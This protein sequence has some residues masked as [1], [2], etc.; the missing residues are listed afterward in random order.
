MKYTIQQFRKD[1]PGDDACPDEPLSPLPTGGRELLTCIS[2][3]TSSQSR[4]PTFTDFAF[5][6]ELESFAYDLFLLDG[7]K[8]V[9]ARDGCYVYRAS[10]PS[11]SCRPTLKRGGRFYQEY[12]E[13]DAILQGQGLLRDRHREAVEH[14]LAEVRR[15]RGG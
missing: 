13:V 10:Y 5:S 2:L 9:R 6:S 14:L 3:L 1:Y 11:G 15:L 7:S 12:R 8:P 4:L